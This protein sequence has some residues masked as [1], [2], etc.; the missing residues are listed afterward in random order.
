MI[1]T[2][3][4]PIIKIVFLGDPC[5]GKTTLLYLWCQIPIDTS[6]EGIMSYHPTIEPLRITRLINQNILVEFW[7]IGGHHYRIMSDE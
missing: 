3:N 4:A 7:D 1:T 5:V 6:T 2:G